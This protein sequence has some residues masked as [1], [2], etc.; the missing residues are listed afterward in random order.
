MKKWKVVIGIL[1]V[2][3]VSIVAFVGVYQK[4][5]GV[6]RNLVADYQYGMDVEGARE[7]RY[8]VDDKE[9]EKYVY[10][11]EQG[12]IQ[13]EVWK[14][15]SSVTQEEEE[16]PE[17]AEDTTDTENVEEV[18]YAKET[19]KIKVNPD[20][21]L[22]KENFEQAKKMI[23]KRLKQEELDEYNLRIDDVTGKLVIESENDDETVH[24]VEQLV[25][26]PGKF[27]IIDY[28][29][30]LV[31]M[32]NLDIKNASV[33]YSN[34]STYNTYLQIEFNK[35]G[36]QKLKDISNKYVEIKEETEGEE[37]EQTEENAEENSEEEKET[38]KKMVSIVFDDDTMMTTYFGEEMSSGLLQIAVGQERTKYEDF[39][40]DYQSAK[41]LANMINSGVLPV[42]YELET[43]NFVKSEWIASKQN[44]E[45][46]FFVILVVVPAIFYIVKFKKNGVLAAILNMG[47]IA[48]LSLIFKYTNVEMTINAV[49]ASILMIVVN[50]A[51]IKM[52][53]KHLETQKIGQA[54]AEVSKKFYL[55]SI[56]LVVTALVFTF[57]KN[58]AIN[59]VGMVV[60]WAM[61]LNVLYNVALTRTVLDRED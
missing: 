24:L 29:N 40:E 1:F 54:Y 25:S 36:A 45:I 11:D 23:Q 51:F 42:T 32:D 60:F 12:N 20:D 33:V 35:E 50:M 44:L 17:N 31:L 52:I 28:Q 41:T 27:Q 6:W 18:P 58:Y 14:E 4:E 47:Y 15:G 2:I 55:A 39:L 26:K 37:Q 61:I 7:L 56:P 46:T 22:T 53:V 30:G 49:F 59:S 19:R 43:D 57:T 48:V 16:N 38:E 3:L 34:Q 13:G 5:N 21:K 9:E 10:V 8:A